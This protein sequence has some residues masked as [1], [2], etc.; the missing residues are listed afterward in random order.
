[1][2]HLIPLEDGADDYSGLSVYG[3]F[4]EFGL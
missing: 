2:L 3:F 4:G 1:M